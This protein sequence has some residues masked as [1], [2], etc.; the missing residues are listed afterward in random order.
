MFLFNAGFLFLISIDSVI[1]R[2]ASSLQVSKILISKSSFLAWWV[3]S[4]VSM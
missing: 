1:L 2:L 3:G 4:I